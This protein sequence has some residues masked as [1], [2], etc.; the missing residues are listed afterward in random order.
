MTTHAAEVHRARD[1]WLHLVRRFPLR[2]IRSERELDRAA[3]VIDELL[4]RPRLDADER[5]YLE[6]LGDLV[7]RYEEKAHPI[8]PASDAELLAFLIEQKG[9]TQ[10]EVSRAAGMPVS[11]VSEILSGKR[12]VPRFKIG[13]LAAFFNIEPAAFAFEHGKAR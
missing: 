13:P 7:E 2:P 12:A 9:V 10:A 5:D 6:V 4:A 8:P 3:G 1:T 11:T